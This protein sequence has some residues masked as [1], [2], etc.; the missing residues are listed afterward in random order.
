[1]TTA[2]SGFEDTARIARKTIPFMS[3][4]KIPISPRNY[5]IWYEYFSGDMNELNNRLDGLLRSNTLFDETVMAEVYGQFF[6]RNL[7]KEG[8]RKLSEEIEAVT[9][10][11]TQTR[12]I[13]AP[14][15]E[16][17]AKLSGDN[18]KYGEKLDNYA[19]SF[20]DVG[21][22][23]EIEATLA[24]LSSDTKKIA[25][26]NKAISKE[27]NSY[28][29]QLEELQADLQKAQSE[30]RVDDLTRVGNRRAFNEKIIEELEWAIE[31]RKFSSLAMLD[32]DHFKKIND[33]YGHPVGDKALQV[34]ASIIKETIDGKGELYRYGGE[35]FTLIL[36]DTDLDE[37][38]KLTDAVRRAVSDNE[39]AVRGKD[40]DISISGGV[41]LIQ[42]MRSAEESLQFSDKALYLAKNSGRNN[43]KSENDL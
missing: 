11:Q 35:E 33:S 24:A 42:L 3:E 20:A 32:I 18:E 31:E 41:S 17:L 12:N 28:S 26:Q 10:A 27:L 36:R 25:S 23:D 7:G 34:I 37:A 15:T 9:K 39:F 38:V 43:V 29:T 6:V 8:E 4:K 40:V 2:N 16:N 1:M 21:S 30:A 13:L 19:D 22:A 5:L 14:P